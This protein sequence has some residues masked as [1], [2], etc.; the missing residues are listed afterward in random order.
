MRKIIVL[1]F[2]TL[3]GVIQGPGGAQEDTSEN[4]KYGGWV[5]PHWD[6]VLDST[7]GKQMS[8]RSDLLLGRKTYD[9]FASY[10]PSHAD[11]WP[12]INEVTKYVASNTMSKAD[13]KN[14]V[15]LRGNVVEELRKIR[16]QEGPD[17]QV[18]GSANFIQTLL[19]NDLVDELWLK[20]FPVTLGKGKKFFDG[21]SIPANFSLIEGKVSSKGV[22][23]AS[24]KRDGEV[25]VAEITA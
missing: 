18:H 10:W 15:I 6:E 14:T 12:G 4:F 11:A 9:I 17:L 25:K 7:M 1:Q 23:V 3:D 24:Y 13:W 19:K 5:A 22:I 16:Q 21:G 2:L 20:I 8:E